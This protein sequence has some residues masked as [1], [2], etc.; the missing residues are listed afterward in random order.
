M[1]YKQLTLD[2]RYEIRAFLQAGFTKIKIAGIIGVHKTTVYRELKRNIGL[3]HYRPLHAQMRA[4][5][6][7]SNARKK[8]RFT[9]TVRWRVENLLRHDFSPEQISGYLAKEHQIHISHETI[10]Q[11]IWSDKKH[12]GHLYTR[13]L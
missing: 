1:P 8:I 9:N 7:R 11:H 6:R 12:G 5:S 10:Y 2:Q 3:M 4:E 13:L